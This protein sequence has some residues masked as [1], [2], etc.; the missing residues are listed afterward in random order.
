M[1]KYKIEKRY[2]HFHDSYTYKLY[3]KGLFGWKEIE[4]V[5]KLSTLIKRL[6]DI[7]S[8][9]ICEGDINQVLLIMKNMEKN[10]GSRESQK[11]TR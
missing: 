4:E 11:T 8:N 5:H 2:N 10:N 1:T 6:E 9:P 7:I 3:K